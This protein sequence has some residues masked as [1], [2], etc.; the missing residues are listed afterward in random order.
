MSQ[1]KLKHSGGNGVIIAAPSSNPA[2][3]RTITL[4]D[5]T[6]NA[7]MA[8]V[9]GI[10]EFDHWHLTDDKTDNTDIT[11]NL[12]RYTQAGGASPLGTGMSE[13]SG[14]FTFPSTG[15]YLV[16]ATPIFQINGFDNCNLSTVVTTNNSSYTSHSVA[17]DGNNGSGVRGGMGSSFSFIDVTNTSNVK[18]KFTV[19]SLGSSSYLVGSSTVIYTGFV[20]AR[21]GDS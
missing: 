3:D 14:I 10:K 19:G 9:N 16:I 7:T 20:F 1:I 18:V 2:A 4:P 13:S 17:L 21:I 5:L 15:K 12:S 11:A 8:T 6:A